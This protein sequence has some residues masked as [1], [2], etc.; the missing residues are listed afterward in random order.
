MNLNIIQSRGILIILLSAGFYVILSFIVDYKRF[1]T[2]F[3]SVQLIYIPLILL[4]VVASIFLKSER[5]RFLLR[6][7]SVNISVKDSFIIFNAGQSLLVTPGSIGNIIKSQFFKDRFGT[8]YSKTV[9]LILVERYYDMLGIISI[10]GLFL[11]FRFDDVLVSP[12]II[13]LGFLP[14]AVFL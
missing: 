5:Q 2:D 4:F 12:I 7:V 11:I 6:T 1:S 14:F 10:I 9:P 13:L 3:Q 8:P